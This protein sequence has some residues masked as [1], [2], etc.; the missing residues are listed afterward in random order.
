MKLLRKLAKKELILF[1]KRD[2]R[3]ARITLSGKYK[4]FTFN[5]EVFYNPTPYDPS[6][7]I[8]FVFV[9]NFASEMNK[10]ALRTLH[11]S[12]LELSCDKISNEIVVAG[13]G[14]NK[15]SDIAEVV[16]YNYLPE[17]IATQKF[18]YLGYCFLPAAA[19]KQNKIYDYLMLQIPMV[20]NR[21][22]YS[23]IGSRFLKPFVIKDLN[24]DNIIT[25]MENFKDDFKETRKINF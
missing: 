19:G 25:M 4:L 12:M 6:K 17:L 9:G 16:H 11:E 10:H 20:L 7:T 22:S 8:K 15:F 18:N 2:L 13:N 21:N 5:R 1:S 14:A 23:G 24:Q 3:M